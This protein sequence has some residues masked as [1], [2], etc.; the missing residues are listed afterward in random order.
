M[1]PI[2]QIRQL[3][4]GEIKAP[5]KIMQQ[6]HG[7]GRLRTQ[8]VWLQHHTVSPLPYRIVFPFMVPFIDPFICLFSSTSP[9]NVY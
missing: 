1:T 5:G 4:F 7:E 2:S 9:R 8:A 3:R 6:E